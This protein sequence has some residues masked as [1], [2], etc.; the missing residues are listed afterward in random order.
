[1][2][3]N[4]YRDTISPAERET[5]ADAG[6]ST[7]GSHDSAGNQQRQAG[8]KP[9]PQVICQEADGRAKLELFGGGHGDQP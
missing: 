5:E 7:Q 8:H 3:K 9:G 6:M 2:T 4:R 1:M